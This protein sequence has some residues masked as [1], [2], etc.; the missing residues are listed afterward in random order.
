M[1]GTLWCFQRHHLMFINLW[2]GY[3]HCPH[4]AEEEAEAQRGSALA[5]CHTAQKRQNWDLIHTARE[6]RVL[7]FSH[8]RLLPC[9]GRVNSAPSKRS[10]S[11]WFNLHLRKNQ[12]A[13]LAQKRWLIEK[14][15]HY[16][17]LAWTV[18]FKLTGTWVSSRSWSVS[19]IDCFSNEFVCD[20]SFSF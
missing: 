14:K 11:H 8:T 18:Y 5:C 20:H 16:Y 4:C 6:S 17:L 15:N 1:L 3:Y 2:S 19:R 13:T 7:S 10:G 12:E 9:K